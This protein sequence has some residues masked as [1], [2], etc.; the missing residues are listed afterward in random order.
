MDTRQYY[1]FGNVVVAHVDKTTRPLGSAVVILD[2][3][4][5]CRQSQ[6]PAVPHRAL[7]AQVALP[8]LVAV[9]SQVAIQHLHELPRASSVPAPPAE[10]STF[11][12]PTKTS[13]LELSGERPFLD[14]GRTMPC[15][16]QM[17]IQPGQR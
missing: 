10:N 7:V 3:L 8:A 11:S 4:F 14:I 6:F 1:R 12:L 15:S 17:A 9:P 2:R 16:S 5:L 13:A